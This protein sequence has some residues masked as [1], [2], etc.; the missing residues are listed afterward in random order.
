MTVV[1]GAVP[2]IEV[3]TDIRSGELRD[4]FLKTVLGCQAI[5]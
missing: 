1:S 2:N 3:T 5:R 4:L